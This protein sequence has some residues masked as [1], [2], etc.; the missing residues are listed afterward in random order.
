[1]EAY[2]QQLEQE[3]LEEMRA[4]VITIT[5][6]MVLPL[7][8]IFWITDLVYAPHYKWEFL[9]LRCLVIPIAFLANYSINR[10]KTLATAQNISLAYV[11]SLAAIINAMILIMAEVKGGRYDSIIC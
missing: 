2:S 3:K 8:L 5:S 11:F 10:A 7:Y 9:F 6:N 1:M 4:V